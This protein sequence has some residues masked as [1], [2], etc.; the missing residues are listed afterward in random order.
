MNKAHCLSVALNGAVEDEKIR[1]LVDMSYE[2][3]KKRGSGYEQT[4]SS[5]FL[6]TAKTAPFES[7]CGVPW[8]FMFYNLFP[9]FYGFRKGTNK[10]CSVIVIYS[11]LL[12]AFS[13]TISKEK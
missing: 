5:Y 6:C 8:D 12:L 10:Q 2:L 9:T 7:P 13:G 1:F 11:M 4:T 3:T